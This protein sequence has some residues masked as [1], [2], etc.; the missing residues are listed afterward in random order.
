MYF[1]I[2]AAIIILFV[3]IVIVVVRID[4]RRF[5]ESQ[6]KQAGRRGELFA[7]QVI[8]EILRD[9]DILL[10]NVKLYANN[11]QAEADNIIIN[12]RGI[13][14]F[15]VKNL[16]GTLLGDEDTYDW[17]Q[18]KDAGYGNAYQKAVKN[19]IKQVK[20]QIYILSKLLKDNG[21]NIWIEGY[22]FFVQ[23][24]SPV[25]SDYVV[26]TQADI[27]RI[28]HDGS[29]RNISETVINNIRG[30]LCGKQKSNC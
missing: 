3:L 23:G 14:I 19:P 1:I 25:Q 4:D 7:R 11:K 22:V 13:F 10:N 30:I 5:I 29:N 24:N 2:F 12:S 8:Q 20:R 9:D 21:I 16:R 18:I 26:D 17:L 15:E 27:D 6:Q 28:I